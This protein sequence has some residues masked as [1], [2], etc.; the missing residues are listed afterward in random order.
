ML[1]TNKRVTRD[2]TMV[3]NKLCGVRTFRHWF[4][5]IYIET[6]RYCRHFD[7]KVPGIRHKMHPLPPNPHVYASPGFASEAGPTQFRIQKE[8]PRSLALAESVSRH[9][10]S[11]GT[12]PACLWPLLSVIE[13]LL[14]SYTLRGR[15]RLK[16]H[17][18]LVW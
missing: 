2:A 8:R 5:P 16:T 13:T 17:L 4:L 12:Y 3:D 1:V 7:A 18:A 10:R 9:G 6:R 15:A 11:G 14:L